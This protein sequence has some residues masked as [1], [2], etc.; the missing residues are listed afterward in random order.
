MEYLAFTVGVVLYIVSCVW[1]AKL[2]VIVR[3]KVLGKS[4]LEYFAWLVFI[5]T[6]IPYSFFFPAWLGES[7][8][9]W[10]RTQSTTLVMI[11]FGIVVSVFSFYKG[12]RVN[13]T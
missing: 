10:Q 7:L 9:L 5:V 11:F 8:A 13:A 4:V 1:I 2:N 6:Y 12:G 3:R